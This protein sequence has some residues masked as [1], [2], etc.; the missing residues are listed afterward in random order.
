[1]P[2]LALV[3]VTELTFDS[4]LLMDDA[5]L[6]LQV[7]RGL[8]EIPFVRGTD[9]IVPRRTGRIA[10]AR[11]GDRLSIELEGLVRG[12]ETLTETEAETYYAL[13]L[14]VK[15]LF[16]P[17]KD[18]ATL[19]C[20]LPDGSTA[21]ILVRVVP[22]LLWEEIIPGRLARLNVAMESVEPDWTITP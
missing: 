7:K 22:P 2:S 14:S 5:G 4:G 12:I 1:M 18:P 16:D 3:P 10:R 11:V 8:G 19:S 20:I 13:V 21:S 6:F 17:T 9:T 15:A